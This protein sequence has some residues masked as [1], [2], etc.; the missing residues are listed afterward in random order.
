MNIKKITQVSETL[1]LLYVEDDALARASTLEMLENFFVNITVAVDGQD[2]LEKFKENDIDLILSD[3]NMPKVDGIKMLEEIR[4][5]DKEVPVMFLSAHNETSYFLDGI[6]LGVDGYILKPL[7][8]TQFIISLQKVTDKIVLKN[9]NENYREHL[10]QKVI[11]RTKELN[12]KLHFD[13]LT[14]LKNRYSFFEDIRDVDVPILLIIDIDKFKIINE[15]YGVSV[16]SMVLKEFANFLLEFSKNSTYQIY[17]LSGDEYILFDNVEHINPEKYENDLKRFFELLKDFTVDINGDTISIEVAIGISTSQ[18]DAFESAKI[19]LDY[20]KTHK[21]PYAMYSKTIDKREEEKDAL[22]WKDITKSAIEDDRVVPVYQAIVDEN[23]EVLKYETLMRLQESDSKK[24]ISPYFF[25]DIAIKTGLYDALS[26]Y[27]IFE[28]LHLVANSSNTFS[29]NFTYGDIKNSVLISEIESFFKLS[30]ELAT[31]VVIE[32]TETQ[33]IESYDDVKEFIK[34]FR[35]YGVK[36]AVDD[37]G[38][39]FSNFEYILEIE[40]DYIKIDGS[41]IKDIDNDNK[42]L[43]LVKA[44]VG[45]SH[46]LG[47][48]VIAEYVHSETVFKMLKEMGVDEYQGFYFAEPVQSI[49]KGDG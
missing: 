9:E 7:E 29:I 1:N 4:V 16:G 5:L 41:L 25:L 48:K 31:R 10:E 43:I 44:I 19:A 26:S 34:R 6:K 20:A 23:G 24:L 21:K 12:E 35:N 11:Q 47:I 42:A 2:G 28:A 37:F 30:P 32:I 45:F 13:E 14:G 38:S 15:I 8:L 49:S 33:S 22:K 36:I 40:P 3:I 17:R 39:G 46:E 18:K 27:V